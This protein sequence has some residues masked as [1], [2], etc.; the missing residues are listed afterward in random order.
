VSRGGVA[1]VLADFASVA[2]RRG[3]AWYVFGAQAAI[4][5]GRPRATADVDVTVVLGSEKPT[6][7]MRGLARRGFSLRV[8][9]G[10][11]FI[12]QARVLPLVHRNGLPLD[13]VLG[14]PGLEEEFAA[15]ARPYDL[16]GV[17]VPTIAAE[18]LIATKVLAGRAKDLED[19]EGILAIQG[20][21]LDLERVRDVLGALEDA[22]GQSDL[23]P[24]FEELLVR[25][26]PRPPRRRAPARRRPKR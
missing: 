11:E 8:P 20:T 16:G 3:L 14:G 25:I 13:V 21:G 4:V 7:L 23:R 24:V 5:Y 22:L 9:A 15:R 10:D 1:E 2:K 6:D 18:D 12:V 19:V 26:H 17:V